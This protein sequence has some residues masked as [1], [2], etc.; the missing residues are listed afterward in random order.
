M[1]LRSILIISISLAAVIGIERAY[2]FQNGGF[3]PSKLTSSLSPILSAP[4]PEIDALL[5]QPFRYFGRGGTSFVFLG[6]DE[7]TILKLFKHQHLL[8]KSRLFHIAIPGI[9]DGLRINKILNTQKKQAHKH[10]CF[11]FN[12]CNLAYSQL[13]EETGL[14]YLN[15]QP[16]PH[17]AKPV[18][19]IDAWG[20]AHSID[21][22]KT[23]FAIQQRAELLFPH[24][25]D[26]FKSGNKEKLKQA[27]DSL[28]EQIQCRCRKG[29]GDRDP[30]L[31]INFGYIDGK[32]VE[33]DL[34]S[35]YLHPA[36]M[37]PMEEAKELFFS[38]HSLQKWL[39]KHCPDLLDYLLDRIARGPT[40]S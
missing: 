28:L 38:T 18:K 23:E 25:E 3:T 32:V 4:P 27:I 39:E 7:K 29:I 33:F 13:K 8:K 37:S 24:L 6:E 19:L 36:L 31:W 9:A 1:N 16:N 11:F 14:I 21:L 17:F 12:S 26:L 2:Y 30:N 20:F 40:H 15:L 10:Q 22:R 5:N 35:F 34:G